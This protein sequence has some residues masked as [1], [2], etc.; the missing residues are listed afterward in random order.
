M[1]CARY[2]RFEKQDWQIIGSLNNKVSWVYA[3]VY[4]FN[5]AK[6]LKGRIGKKERRYGH[7]SNGGG[8]CLGCG[9]GH[10]AILTP[11]ISCKS[12]LFFFFSLLARN[13]A[14]RGPSQGIHYEAS[15]SK[16]SG[17]L[18]VLSH[19]DVKIHSLRRPIRRNL[20]N[21]FR[22]DFFLC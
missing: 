1:V 9:S 18:E 12:F 4:Y 20:A 10:L 5:Q 16:Y 14:V 22:R 2:F 11:Y 21:K 7:S 13:R 6:C 3:T 15:S 19:F 17:N 8:R